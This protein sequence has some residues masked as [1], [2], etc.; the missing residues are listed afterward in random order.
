M[1][2]LG[3]VWAGVGAVFGSALHACVSKHTLVEASAD[4]YPASWERPLLPHSHAHFQMALLEQ[5]GKAFW[6]PGPP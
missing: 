2:V 6:E 5:T 3:M 1:A 4:I